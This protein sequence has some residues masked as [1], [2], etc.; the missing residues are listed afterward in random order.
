MSAVMSS[1]PERLDV[2]KG[3]MV[4]DEYIKLIA[5]CVVPD[6]QIRRALRFYKPPAAVD[7]ERVRSFGNTLRVLKHFECQQDEGEL[8]QVMELLRGKTSL[9]EVGSCFGGSLKRMASALAPESLVVSVDFQ[10]PPETD[11]DRFRDSLQ[12][13]ASLKEACHQINLTMGHRVELFLGN[14]RSSSVIQGVAE[15]APFDFGF[16]DGDHSYEGVKADWENYGPM[17]KVVGFHD[18]AGPVDGCVRLW[19]EIVKEGKYRTQEFVNTAS[20]YSGL[21]IGVVFREDG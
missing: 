18:I 3:P 1:L 11:L 21:G 4:I 6:E 8:W 9:L 13:Q 17:C 19:N 5:A 7:L 12:P 20:G 15:H 16:I 14:S 10:T 2:P